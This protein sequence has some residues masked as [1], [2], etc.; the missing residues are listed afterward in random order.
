MIEIISKMENDILW[1]IWIVGVFLWW[2]VNKIAD[3]YAGPPQ[4]PS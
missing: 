3:W 4:P 2:I 1:V